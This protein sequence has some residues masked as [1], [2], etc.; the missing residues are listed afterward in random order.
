MNGKR[1]MLI[2][3]IRITTVSKAVFAFS[4]WADASVI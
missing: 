4:R 1:S 2:L 3:S